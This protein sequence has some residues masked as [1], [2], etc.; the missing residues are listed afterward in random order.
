MRS[1]DGT[2]TETITETLQLIMD[3]LIPEDKH[4]EDTP[5]HRTIRDQTKQPL[6]TMDD[7]EFTKEEVKQVI[8]SLQPKKAP[9][10]NGI[11]NEI[12][13]LVFKEIPKT[14][15]ATYNACL[16][17]GRFPV[18]W[19]IAK[20]LPIAK[21]GREKSADTSK[22]RPIS[23]LNTEGKVLEKLLSKRITHHLYTT[24][25]L[26]ENQYG[27]TP[28]KNTVDAAM[29]VKQYL[30]N[31]LERGGVA[32]MVSLDVQGA[33]DS[34]WWPAILQRLREAK[35]PR[36]LYYLVQDYLKEREAFIAINSYSMRKNITKDAHKGH[37]AVQYYGTFNTTQFLTFNLPTIQ[38]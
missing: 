32:I 29:Q 12:I 10:P 15:T 27:F 3:Q 24:E 17:T 1:P 19:K 5:Y 28:Q 2:K 4:K 35:C 16:R 36:N 11:T 33:F 37:A 6:Y 9:G 14:M 23:L 30:E 31:H 8:E 18:N 7:K 38:E 26:N 20:I 25:Y 13:K 21:P 22:Y 34:A